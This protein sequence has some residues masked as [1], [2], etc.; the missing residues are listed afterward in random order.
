MDFEK[1]KYFIPP[2][3]SKEGITEELKKI[4]EEAKKENIWL[5]EFESSQIY[6]AAAGSHKL[7]EKIGRVKVDPELLSLSDCME[8]GMIAKGNT[9][10]EACRKAIENF[11]RYFSSALK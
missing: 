3:A 8:R 9:R 4:Y 11:K 1:P 5:R 6:W 10:E 2:E 7:D